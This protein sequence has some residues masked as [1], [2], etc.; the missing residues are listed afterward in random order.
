MSSK[1]SAKKLVDTFHGVLPMGF[2][3]QL[4]HSHVL[5]FSAA[6]NYL[7]KAW[8]DFPSKKILQTNIYPVTNGLG[9][10]WKVSSGLVVLPVLGIIA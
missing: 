7:S 10:R 2:F 9:R 1:S 3:S 4:V 8:G 6:D 5:L